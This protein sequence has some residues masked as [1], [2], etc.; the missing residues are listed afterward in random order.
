MWKRN[1]LMTPI[2]GGV[3]IRASMAVDSGSTFADEDGA[4]AK[5]KDAIDLTSLPASQ[6]W[7]D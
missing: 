6:W 3:E 1:R 5:A 7:W 4:V 2:G